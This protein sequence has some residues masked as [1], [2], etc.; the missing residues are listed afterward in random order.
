MMKNKGQ[1]S[2]LSKL[3]RTLKADR[4]VGNRFWIL[5]SNNMENCWQFAWLEIRLNKSTIVGFAYD[6]PIDADKPLPMYFV[7]YADKPKSK[8]VK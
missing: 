4:V 3:P 7:D 1:I 6:K 5:V 8:G 2:H